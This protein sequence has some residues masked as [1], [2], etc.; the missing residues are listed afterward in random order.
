MSAFSY[1][2]GMARASLLS[3]QGDWLT[4]QSADDSK[5][6][7]TVVAMV[8][9]VEGGFQDEENVQVKMQRRTIQVPL[10]IAN[11]GPSDRQRGGRYTIAGEVWTVQAETLTD[12]KT[13]L[14]T[15]DLRRPLRADPA[16]RRER[17]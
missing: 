4:F 3:Q 10:D 6:P 15:L 13:G 16:V 5:I 2:F 7:E 12:H 8:G 1:A 11:G 9:S 17:T 14:A